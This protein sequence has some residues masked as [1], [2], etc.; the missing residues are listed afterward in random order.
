MFPKIDSV[1]SNYK[2]ETVEVPKQESKTGVS[3]IPKQDRK[4][5]AVRKETAT[6]LPC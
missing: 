6:V 1:Q 5:G 3:E 2:F 4:S